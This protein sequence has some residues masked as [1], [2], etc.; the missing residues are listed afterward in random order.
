MIV[1]RMILNNF[2]KGYTLIPNPSPV[3]ERRE[4][5]VQAPF[6]QNGRRVGDEGV[7]FNQVIGKVTPRCP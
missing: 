6:S 3:N 1:I 5:K 7:Q 2:F 4:I